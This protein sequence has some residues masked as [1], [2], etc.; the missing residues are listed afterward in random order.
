MIN[1]ELD[2]CPTYGWMTSPEFDTLVKSLRNGHERRRPRWNMC[3]HKYTLPFS[4]LRD[5][6]YLD[7]LKAAFLSARGRTESFRVKDYSDFRADNDVLG[8][9]DGVTLSFPLIRQYTFGD[10]SYVRRITWP[11]NPVYTVNGTPVSATF[12]PASGNVVFDVAPADGTVIR[13]SGE[14]RVTVRF[15][16][17][18]MPMAIHAKNAGNYLLQG[19]VTLVEVWE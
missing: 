19:S 17:D 2:L 11:V 4:A 6:K 16:S 8:A 12:D 10:A 13:W 3:K 1:A 18:A 15:E 14:F 9:G 7:K 5:I